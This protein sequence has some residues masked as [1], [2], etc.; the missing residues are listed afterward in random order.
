MSWF[1]PGDAQVRPDFV[2]HAD[3]RGEHAFE[4]LEPSGAPPTPTPTAEPEEPDPEHFWLLGYAAGR[5]ATRD[6]LPFREAEGLALATE[7]LVR[8]AGELASLRREYL[9]SNRR[10]LVDLAIAI[11]ERILERELAHDPDVLAALVERSL[12]SLAEEGPIRLLL[13]D[14]DREVLR[15]ADSSRLAALRDEGGLE[16]ETAADLSR[17]EVRLQAGAAEMDARIQTLLGLVRE[18]LEE[19]LSQNGDLA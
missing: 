18:G 4:T 14:A 16:I 1:E 12:E 15:S 13:C 10:E 11:A 17:G 19:C 3:A 7:A 9:S 5:D 8:A 2:P 6:E